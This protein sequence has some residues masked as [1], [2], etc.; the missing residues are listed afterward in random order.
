MQL[1]TLTSCFLALAALA[2][3]AQLSPITNFGANPSGAKMYLYV[4]DKLAA[5]P[6]IVVAIHYVGKPPLP[7]SHPPSY[8]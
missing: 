2:H 7:R 8:P 4:P 1:P 3:A 6:P 5:N